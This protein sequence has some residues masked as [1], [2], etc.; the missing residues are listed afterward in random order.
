MSGTQ[1]HVPNCS[2]VTFDQLLHA[3][4]VRGISGIA[5][6][7]VSVV[8]LFSLVFIFRAYKNTLQRLILYYAITTTIYQ[9]FNVSFLEHQF[10]YKWQDTICAVL[11]GCINYTVGVS[12]I[13]SAIIV[14]Y[15]MYLV[16]R[17]LEKCGRAF[18]PQRNRSKVLA[19][20]F[21]VLFALIIPLLYAWAPLTDHHYGISGPY[22]G[23]QTTDKN[24]NPSYRDMI[25]FI[26]VGEFIEVE[27]F[28][29]VITTL[30]VYCR[31]RRRVPIKSMDM[32]VQKTCFL[33]VL[34][35]ILVAVTTVLLVMTPLLT[36]KDD[37]V[38]YFRHQIA[39][40][41][42][43]PLFFEFTLIIMFAVSARISERSFVCSCTHSS[44]KAVV[45][46]STGNYKTTPTSCPLH[47][48]SETCYFPSHTNDFTNVSTVISPSERDPLLHGEI[49]Q[50]LYSER[51]TS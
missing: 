37:P 23:I 40:A 3:N 25:I 17:A 39:N 48:P 10:Q 16:L 21:F 1:F 47:Q 28:V 11:G 32:L 45:D 15:S 50:Q 30:I 8:L 12:I 46:N 29:V 34:Y 9:A 51:P 4:L 43:F 31:I 36:L 19:E 44:S 42:G 13:L 24:C 22:C 18:N 33:S 41:F 5:C 49:M 20:C 7:L 27:M 35:S 26:A 38:S 2:N 14:N 6:F